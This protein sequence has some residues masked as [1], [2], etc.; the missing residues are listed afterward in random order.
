MFSRSSRC[1]FTLPA[2]LPLAGTDTAPCEAD[3]REEARQVVDDD[4]EEEEDGLDTDTEAETGAANLAV[5]PLEA[6]LAPSAFFASGI[7]AEVEGG[8]GEETES[9]AG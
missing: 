5:G 7:R 8:E 6:S 3:A 4:D 1:A 9:V 2:V